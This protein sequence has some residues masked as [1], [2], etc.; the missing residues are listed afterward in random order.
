[1]KSIFYYPIE[2]KIIKTILSKIRYKMKILTLISIFIL[3]TKQKRI[4]K[5][6]SSEY[7]NWISGVHEISSVRIKG[8]RKEKRT[9]KEVGW[10]NNR[11][12][13][14]FPAPSY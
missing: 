6:K 2:N 10:N 1:M 4:I 11:L 8:S 14:V 5:S 9:F 12:S 7:K 3:S 13:T